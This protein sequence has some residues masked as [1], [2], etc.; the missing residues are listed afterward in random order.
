MAI[1]K[2]FLSTILLFLGIS[3][4]VSCKLITEI[5]SFGR[6]VGKSICNG[7][8]ATSI[9]SVALE[10]GLGKFVDHDEMI[11][12]RIYIANIMFRNSLLGTWA[13]RRHMTCL[14][15]AQGCA[16]YIAQLSFLHSPHRVVQ[17]DA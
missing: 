14:A 11:V 2:L 13:R 16:R 12:H 10:P 15:L 17:P 6:N 8:T 9:S 7:C 3:I 1:F 5:V 4:W